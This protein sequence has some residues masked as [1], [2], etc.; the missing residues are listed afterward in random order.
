[1]SIQQAAPPTTEIQFKEGGIHEGLSDYLDDFYNET[2]FSLGRTLLV[3]DSL[4]GTLTVIEIVLDS[5]SSR[6]RGYAVM[7]EAEEE[8]LYFVDVDRAN[9]VL[10]YTDVLNEVSEQITGIDT[11]EFYDETDR[12]DFYSILQNVENGNAP[13]GSTQNPTLRRRRFWGWT[14]L[15]PAPISGLPNTCRCVKYYDI[16]WI[17]IYTAGPDLCPC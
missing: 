14:H 15:P 3:T 6:A 13:D 5:D 7:D 10:S 8:F 17:Q 1:M 9:H 12:Y 4:L 2:G 16:F 11:L